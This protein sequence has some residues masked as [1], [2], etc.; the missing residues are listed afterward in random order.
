M[1]D[2]IASITVQE[3]RV[4]VLISKGHKQKDVATM[5]GSHQPRV[6]QIIKKI[7]HLYGI[8]TLEGSK[9]SRR[10]SAA[11]MKL[12]SQFEAALDI[13]AGKSDEAHLREKVAVL[14]IALRDLSEIANSI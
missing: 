14:K 13:L 4:I 10:I 11:G 2:P 5:M 3:M 7:D 9:S 12:A 8:H 1:K 6:A